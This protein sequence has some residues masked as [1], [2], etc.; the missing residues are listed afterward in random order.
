MSILLIFLL[1]I[2]FLSSYTDST[3]SNC[4]NHLTDLENGRIYEITKI[5]G[6]PSCVTMAQ[7]IRQDIAGLL[8]LIENDKPGVLEKVAKVEN[9]I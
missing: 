5:P 4:S 1:A 7:H 6:E 8:D 9:K 2:S 3:T